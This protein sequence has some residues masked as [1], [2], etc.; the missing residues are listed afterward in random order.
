MGEGMS[1]HRI[2][3]I[4]LGRVGGEFLKKMVGMKEKGIEVVAV[5]ELSETPGKVLARSYDIPVKSDKEIVNMG[6]DVDI[7]FDMSGIA[8]VRRGLRE[9]LSVSQNYHT[10]IAPENIAH[11]IWVLISSEKLPEVHERSGY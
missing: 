6:S 10:V 11:F 7:I 1:D 8:S 3:I 2:A 4:G 9:M 5:A